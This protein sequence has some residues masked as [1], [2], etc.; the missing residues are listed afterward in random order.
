MQ[1][2]KASQP[3][4]MFRSYRP[5]FLSIL[6]VLLVGA[7]LYAAS[8]YVASRGETSPQEL[9]VISQETL[10]K[11][12]GLGVNLVAVTAAGG[13]VDLRLQILDAEKAKAFL[14]DPANMPALSV[15]DDVV[16]R[17][18]EEGA[19]Q[20]IQ[21][22]NG[23]SIFVLYPNAQN[24]VKTGVPVSLQFGDLLVGPIPAK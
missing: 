14:E 12:Y 9:V 1:S 17:V 8:L 19:M 5:L 22:E 7:G 20:D 3:N 21:F 23:K 6:F 10:A 13:M 15:G 2:V 4:Q 11:Q 24:I 16:L 18:N